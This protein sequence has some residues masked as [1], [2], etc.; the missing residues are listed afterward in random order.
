MLS[1]SEE[2]R[3]ELS[4]LYKE[5][6]SILGDV[7]LRTLKTIDS[8]LVTTLQPLLDTLSETRESCTQKYV[9]RL[10]SIRSRILYLQKLKEE[11]VQN[12]GAWHKMRDK[13]NRRSIS[14]EIQEILR[15]KH[16]KL[17]TSESAFYEAKSTIIDEVGALTEQ[18]YND[19][20]PL[21]LRVSLLL[22]V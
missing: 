6:E 18:H 1:S 21:L 16:E 13:H 11:F 8:S 20:D 9:K 14:P 22:C 12:Q 2:I 7:L 19:L 3:N 4:K 15:K 17:L 10:N 5:E